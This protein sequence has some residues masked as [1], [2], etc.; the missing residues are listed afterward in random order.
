[1]PLGETNAKAEWKES[2]AP[3][4]LVEI[5]SRPKNTFRRCKK[6]GFFLFSHTRWA[7]VAGHAFAGLFLFA[8]AGPSVYL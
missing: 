8:A 5:R 7:Q 3:D 4:G 6:E 2:R 1:L